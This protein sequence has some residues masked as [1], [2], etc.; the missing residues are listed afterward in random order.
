[1]VFELGVGL[2]VD[3]ALL[4]DRDLLAILTNDVNDAEHSRTDGAGVSEPLLAVAVH[5]P[6]ALG[7]GV[8]LVDD[9]TPP[10]DHLSFH[11]NRARCRRVDAR[12]Q[13]RHVVLVPSRIIELEHANEHGG[14][15]LRD[16]DLMLLDQTQVVRRI[17]LLHHDDGAAGDVRAHAE[18]QR[19]SVVERGGR[20]VAR[21]LVGSEKQGEQ[22]GDTG[23]SLLKRRL[24]HSRQHPLGTASRA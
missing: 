22:A 7:T 1:M 12:L 2:E 24:W 3:R 11:F 10:L 6:V 13:R 16:R 18:T 9:R 17:E 8:I 19:S 23:A 15:H 14:D 20:E 4:P 5:E 21:L